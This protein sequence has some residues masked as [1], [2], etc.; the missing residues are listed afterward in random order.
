METNKYY[1]SINI[2]HNS[3]ASIMRNGEIIF[4]ACEER[5]R[6]IKNIVCYPKNAI[7]ACIKF[8]D[9]SP[10][11]LT[12]ASFTSSDSDPVLIKSKHVNKFNI[13]DFWGYYDDKFYNASLNQKIKY[14]KWLLKDKKFNDK[15]DLVDYKFLKS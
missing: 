10:K 9:I 13:K 5:Y 7:E 8:A 15:E 14:Y 12:R 6:K 1:L 2:S 11:E 3:S 4:A